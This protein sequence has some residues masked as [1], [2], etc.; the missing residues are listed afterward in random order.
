MLEK[1]AVFAQEGSII[2]LDRQR[3]LLNGAKPD[4]LEVTVVVGR[5]GSFDL[6]DDDG[7]ECVIEDVDFR[8]D[9]NYVLSVSIGSV[10]A[11]AKSA[12]EKRN[13]TFSFLI[14]DSVKSIRALVDNF[15]CE[16]N[17]SCRFTI[18]FLAQ[19]HLH[20]C[21]IFMLQFCIST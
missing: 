19:K 7:N 6:C 13:W 12:V 16:R 3:C 18:Q 9:T 1:Y 21:F 15:D 11:K 5:D 17:A 2:P 10:A 8:I 4:S 14:L 20:I